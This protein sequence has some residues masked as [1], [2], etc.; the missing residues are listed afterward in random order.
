MVLCRRIGD[1]LRCA[2]V[3]IPIVVIPMW[4]AGVVRG[5]MR[6]ALVLRIQGFRERASASSCHRAA[7]ASWVTAGREAPLRR[8]PYRAAPKTL[9]PAPSESLTACIE[10]SSVNFVSR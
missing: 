10:P 5:R 7:P 1:H 3:V 4:C 6:C 2:G 9:T 8:G